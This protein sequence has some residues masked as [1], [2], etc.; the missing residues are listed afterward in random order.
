[1]MARRDALIQITK[2]LLQRRDELRRRLGT[3]LNDLVNES[4][5]SVGDAADAAF[6]AAGEELASHLAE[7]ESK[8]LAQV[9]TALARIKQGRYGI[10]DGCDQKILVA[11]LNALPYSTLCI[12]CQRQA[13]DDDRWEPRYANSSTWGDLADAGDEREISIHEIEMDLTK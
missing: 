10:C 8:E 11:R 6:D 4:Q 3:G 1:M 9:E 13:D 12:E 7:F 2:T 5:D